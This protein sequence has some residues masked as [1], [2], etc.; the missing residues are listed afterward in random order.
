[1]ICIKCR[2]EV[3]DA[4]FCCQCGAAQQ[5]PSQNPKSRG[6]GTGSVYKLHSGKYIAVKTI[7]YYLDDNGHKH[8]KTASKTFTR[9][10][11]AVNSVATLGLGKSATKA[12]KKPSTTFRQLYDLWLPTH[13]ASRD[14]LN[15][16]KAAI[17]YFRPIYFERIIDID[18]DDLQECIDD[19]PKGKSTKHNMKT[20]CGLIYKYGIPRGYLPEKLNLA[21]YL[22]VSGETGSGGTALP[23]DYLDKIS[24]AVGKVYG[25]DYV[26]CQCYLG[27]RPS[28][29]LALDVKDYD[30]HEKVFHGGA[31]TEAGKNRAVTVSPK[32]QGIVD[33]LTRSK[34]AGAV[35]CGSEGDQMDIADYREMFYSVL[36]A[37][38]LDNPIIEVDGKQR[39]TYTP[40]SCRHTFA[41]LMKRV[42]AAS[43]DKL[44]LIGHSSEE[45]L[46]YYQ[47]VSYDDLRKIT[48]S[49]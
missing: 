19:C 27:F 48:D 45:M 12:E 36:D 21:D 25:A 46:H 31:K 39:H 1:M 17:K 38:G 33:T 32:I 6:N 44:E 16:Y 29:F 3:P 2:R 28:E 22:K 11:D 18:V 9:R 7:G 24:K 15:C 42:G 4:P 49:I 30:R 5:L 47:D 41:T 43:K 23:D 35:F 10:R 34:A 40:H 37:L 26:Y 13:I 14:T 20:V 8:R